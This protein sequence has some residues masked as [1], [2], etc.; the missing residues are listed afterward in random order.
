VRKLV[1]EA[2]ADSK[3]RHRRTRYRFP[4]NFQ[5]PSVIHYTS[6][7]ARADSS[8]KALLNG[9]TSQENLKDVRL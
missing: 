7:L 8:E 5:K 1:F 9:A 6:A 4:L 3:N 2:K